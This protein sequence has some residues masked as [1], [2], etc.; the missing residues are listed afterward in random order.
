MKQKLP[1]GSR[2]LTRAA[3]YSGVAALVLL[4]EIL[5]RT[6]RLDP[7][8]PRFSQA[9]A[10]LGRLLLEGVLF[11]SVMVSLWRALLGLLIAA[12][13]AIPLGFLL[14]RL[15]VT[16]QCVNPLF[17]MLAQV[18]PFSLMPV[19]ILFF[20]IGERVKIA[21]VA[22]VSLWPLLFNT[23]EGARNIDPVI[24]KTARAMASSGLA[25]VFR[26]MV[27]GAAASMVAG[28]RLAL[29]M[30]FFMLIVA[31]MT[32]ASSGLGWLLHNSAMN[33][34]FVRM[35]ASILAIVVL[36]F[37]ISKF[38]KAVQ[39]NRVG[40]PAAAGLLI[41][42]LVLGTWQIGVSQR[43]QENFNHTPTGHMPAGGGME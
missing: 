15:S 40:F 10:G 9:L 17:R 16:R 4:W 14:G 35:Y 19:F 29:E 21:V 36:G 37:G 12:A 20:G 6:N 30:S 25:L 41:L 39:K 31:E 24:I 13:A 27:P 26:V 43:Q 1:A 34:Q 11:T 18:N 38:L 8:L 28:I 5:P 3:E 42:V 2:L 32:G 23:I 7:F 22:W 33:I